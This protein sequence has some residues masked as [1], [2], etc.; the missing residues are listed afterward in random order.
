MALQSRSRRPTKVRLMDTTSF[1]C[2][3]NTAKS[4]EKPQVWFRSETHLKYIRSL[5][6][7]DAGHEAEGTTEADHLRIG[8]DA[9]GSVKASDFLALPLS[10]FGHRRRHTV[11]E[12][13]FYNSIGVYDRIATALELAARS[14]CLKT[15]QAAAR[16]QAT[17]D[18]REAEA[19]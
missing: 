14:P 19:S 15:R 5:P 16:W 18:W 10:A 4:A 8:T 7:L 17:G 12:A 2:A 1:R 13:G 6:P 3:P 11:G 9:A